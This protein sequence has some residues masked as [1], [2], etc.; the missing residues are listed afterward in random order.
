[1]CQY[2][3]TTLNCAS[4]HKLQL[5]WDL[6]G[7][8]GFLWGLA[9]LFLINILFHAKP[10]HFTNTNSNSVTTELSAENPVY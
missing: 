1:M 5:L 7:F 3:W 8:F 10:N 2:H 4:T 9:G 6:F